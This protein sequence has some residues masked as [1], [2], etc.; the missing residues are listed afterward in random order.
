MRGVGN[1]PYHWCGETTTLR[2]IDTQSFILKNSVADSPYHWYAESAT[3]LIGDSGESFFEYEYLCEFEANQNGSKGSVRDSWGTNFCKNPRKSASLPCP[4]K[5]PRSQFPAWWAGTTTLY[6]TYRPARLH[7][8]AESIPGL[9][10]HVY[11]FWLWL[12]FCIL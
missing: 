12:H 8:P 7:R 11:K 4:F 6:L 9:L 5:E 1:S 10:K 3:P 2:I